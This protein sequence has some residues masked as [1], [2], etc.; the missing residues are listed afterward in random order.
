MTIEPVLEGDLTHYS[1]LN[2]LKNCLAYHTNNNDLVMVKT[3]VDEPLASQVLDLKIFDS[4][5]NLLRY[6]HD[7]TGESTVIFKNLNNEPI[8]DGNNIKR[9][10]I[11]DKL[12]FGKSDEEKMKQLMDKTTGKNLVY[13]CFDNIYSDKSWSFV[14]GNREVELYVDL[15]DVSKMTTT[16]YNIYSKYFHRFQSNENLDHKL[17]SM[18]EENFEKEI[19][20]IENELND[21]VENLKNLAIILNNIVDQESKLRDVNEQIFAGYSIMTSVILIVIFVG[22]IFQIVYITKYL[23]RRLA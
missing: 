13:V 21:V 5:D 11:I 12:P 23:T 20:V 1:T 17:K 6:S 7:I 9:S 3:V 14:P 15:R 10:N 2:N 8:Y 18:D 4:E 22:G 19:S 16:D